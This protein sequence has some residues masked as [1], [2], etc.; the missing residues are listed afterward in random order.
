MFPEASV[1]ADSVDLRSISLMVYR[2]SQ[3]S[4]CPSVSRDSRPL[5]VP[6]C[7]V[8]FHFSISPKAFSS[9]EPGTPHSA[10]LGTLAASEGTTQTAHHPGAP[11]SVKAFLGNGITV[12]WGQMHLHAEA[13][14]KDLGP[15]GVGPADHLLTLFYHWRCFSDQVW[16]V[17]LRH[18]HGA[19]NSSDEQAT[20][21]GH[22]FKVLGNIY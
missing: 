15:D 13:G 6:L 21:W 11:L 5:W 7:W 2:S 1:I 9:P 22:A 10:C 4:M 12:L 17:Q 16:E 19:T 3:P 14:E 20:H 8:G 18:L